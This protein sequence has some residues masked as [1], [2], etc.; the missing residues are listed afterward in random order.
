MLSARFV[1][2][3]LKPLVSLLVGVGGALCLAVFMVTQ[4]QAVEDVER[5]TV[6]SS[7]KVLVAYLFGSACEGLIWLDQ[8]LPGGQRFFDS[9]P[10]S[11]FSLVEAGAVFALL[12]LYWVQRE[13]VR[14]RSMAVLAW[15]YG[16]ISFV[17]ASLLGFVVWTIHMQV[18][19][20][21]FPAPR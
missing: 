10:W 14:G 15:C 4:N 9:H 20:P 3:M 7:P 17:G 16:V 6:R 13:R 11:E 8:P 1:Y 12:A 2:S 5:E 21:V 18:G 19:S